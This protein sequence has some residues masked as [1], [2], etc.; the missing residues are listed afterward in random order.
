MDKTALTAPLPSA[1]DPGH[2]AAKN[3]RLAARFAYAKAE[4]PGYLTAVVGRGAAIHACVTTVKGYNGYLHPRTCCQ[5]HSPAFYAWEYDPVGDD[6][7]VTCKRCLASLD[8][9]GLA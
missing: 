8:K 9:K 1:V 5:P 4:G 6:R 2:A 3:A 7:A